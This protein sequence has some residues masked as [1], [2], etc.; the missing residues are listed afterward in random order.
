[1]RLIFLKY[2]IIILSGIMVSV[3]LQAQVQFSTLIDAGE[4]NV[5][6]G[7]FIKTTILGAYQLDKIKV[8]GGGQFDLKSASSNFFTGV[9]LILSREFSIKEFQFEIQ[10]LFIGNF[11]SDLAHEY[12]WGFLAYHERKHFT[13]MLGTEFRTYH[14]TQ[15]ASEEYDIES[16]RNLHE[17]WNIMYLAGYNVKP[18]DCK[19]NIGLTI[20]NI[21]H[22]IINQEINP[23]YYLNGKY[24]ITPPLTLYVETWYK[25]SGTNNIS[26]NYFGFLIRTGLIWKLDLKK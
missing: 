24:S 19:W 6:D 25:N 11:F 20:T 4:N 2:L 8:K 23:M 9:T 15:N 7:L 22:F 13:F 3:Q 16:N 10:G 17:N 1:M 5:S 14:I 18:I 21:D 12:D 26:A